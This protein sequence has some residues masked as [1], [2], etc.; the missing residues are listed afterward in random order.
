[1]FKH[2]KCYRVNI[3]ISHFEVGKPP[4]AKPQIKHRYLKR[5]TTNVKLKRPL[6]SSRPYDMNVRNKTVSILSRCSIKQWKNTK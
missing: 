6:F 5:R 3:P 1:M 2:A 4:S